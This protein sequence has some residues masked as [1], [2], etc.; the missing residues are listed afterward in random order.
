MVFS[1][2]QVRQLKP[3]DLKSSAQEVVTLGL[4]ALLLVTVLCLSEGAMCNQ[5]PLCAPNEV[6]PPQSNTQGHSSWPQCLSEHSA[7]PQPQP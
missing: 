7:C 1:I 4:E 2:F 6:Q 5:N 3:R